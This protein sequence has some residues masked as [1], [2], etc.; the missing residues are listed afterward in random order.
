MRNSFD[1]LQGLG[2]ELRRRLGD[3]SRF[4][5]RGQS[6]VSRRAAVRDGIIEDVGEVR[7]AGQGLQL[8]AS[9]GASVLVSHDDLLP[10]TIEALAAQGGK[11]L[12]SAEGQNKLRLRERTTGRVRAV[13]GERRDY[14][15]EHVCVAFSPEIF[16]SRL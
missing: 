4:I 15:N 14:I 8:Y 2:N 5:W 1:D 9:N 11:L 7:G 12:A 10:Q 16:I 6:S 3:G 13:L